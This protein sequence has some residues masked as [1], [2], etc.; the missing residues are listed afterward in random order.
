MNIISFKVCFPFNLI[1][2]NIITDKPSK[3]LLCKINKNFEKSEKAINRDFLI[4]L[5]KQ[6]KRIFSHNELVKY[7]SKME[8]NLFNF[9]DFY[10][11]LFNIGILDENKL[12]EHGKFLEKTASWS[13]NENDSKVKIKI[14][15]DPNNLNVT[16][17]YIEP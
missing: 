2:L 13:I 16:T 10:W 17:S 4:E 9:S 5:R 1:I 15:Q 14:L 6:S 8:I 3:L 11:F 12:I 7:I